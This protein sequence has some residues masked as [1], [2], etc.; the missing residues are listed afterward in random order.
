MNEDILRKYKSYLRQE[1]GTENTIKAYYDGIKH[2]GDFIDKPLRETTIE[3]LSR[4]K[5]CINGT[6]SQN[7]VRIWLY[8]VNKCY[9]WLKKPEIKISIPAQAR[10]NRIV[11]SEDEKNRFL[12]KATENPLHNVIALGLYDEILRPD[13]LINLRISD[14]DFDS[15]MLYIKDSKIGNTSSPYE[16]TFR[17]SSDRLFED[18]SKSKTEVQGFFAHTR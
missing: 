12:Q 1:H 18:Q 2:Y 16:S 4:W 7:T 9:K 6:Y 5:E 3:D 15:H 10:A 13:E 8:A 11:F 14:I 17:A